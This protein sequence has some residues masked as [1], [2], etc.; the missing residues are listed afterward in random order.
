MNRI[1]SKE[2]KKNNN[3]I[4]YPKWISENDDN[5]LIG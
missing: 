4:K 2:R 1:L 5:L 3:F